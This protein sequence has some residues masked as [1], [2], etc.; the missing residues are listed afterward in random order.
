V[1]IGGQMQQVLLDRAVAYIALAWVVVA[2]FVGLM[3]SEWKKRRFWSWVALSLL[4]GPIAWYLLFVRLG[5]AV[6]RELAVTCPHC[7]K[8]TRSDQ[9]TCL[10]CRRLLVEEQ[11]DRATN[12]GR[13]AAAI[14]VM[15]KGMAGR[16]TKAAAKAVEQQRQAAKDRTAQRPG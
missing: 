11:K 4:T 5:V 3:A 7:H 10:H 13:Q 9:K 12:V 16:S 6:P 2:I 8:I 15:A 1:D 14:W